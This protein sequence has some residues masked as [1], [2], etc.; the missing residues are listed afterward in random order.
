MRATY[1]TGTFISC[2]SEGV[3]DQENIL[4]LQ[5]LWNWNSNFVLSLRL[6]SC[7]FKILTNY[8]SICFRA[9]YFLYTSTYNS[10][11]YLTYNIYTDKWNNYAVEE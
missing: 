6:L 4:L 2:H 10:R 5:H 8:H 9:T 1:L 3:Q 11:L 7:N